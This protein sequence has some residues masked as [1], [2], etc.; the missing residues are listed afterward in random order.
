M[1][2]IYKVTNQVN[3][4]VYI[5]KTSWDVNVRWNAHVSTSFNDKCREHKFKFHNAIRKYGKDSFVVEVLEEVDDTE[6]A[7]REQY[8]IEFYNSIK[9][10]YNTTLGGEG[11]MRYSDE[12][13]VECWK[14]GMTY[15]QISKLV[16]ISRNTLS[17][18]CKKLFSEEERLDRKRN[19]LKKANGTEVFQYDRQWNYIMSYPSVQ[20]AT[21]ITGIHH[22]DQVARG[23]RNHAGGYF[24]S[25]KKV[26]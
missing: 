16:G 19:N 12:F 25:Y 22:I 26:G 20:D 14:S 8:W 3:G 6:I 2:Y 21:R 13:I 18:R 9:N 24:W 15:A 5:G 7:T 17:A 23:K 11:S 4:K 10:G 1:G